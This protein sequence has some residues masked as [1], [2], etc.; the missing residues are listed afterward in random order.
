MILT[1]KPVVAAGT[2]L[3]LA[4]SVIERLAVLLAAGVTP[5]SG[6]RYVAEQGSG[7]SGEWLKA[8]VAAVEDGRDVADAILERV[9][10]TRSGDT[11]AWRGVAAAWS[12]ATVSGAPLAPTLHNFAASLR[13]LAQTQRDIV[14]A[15]T[16]PAATA[17]MVTG[18]PLVGILFGTLLGF[19]TLRTLF[20]TASGWACLAVGGALIVAA[21]AWNRRLIR[22]ALPAEVTPGLSLDLLAIAVSGGTSI[23]KAVSVVTEAC[24]R[25][26]V[27][28][29]G[30]V[31]AADIL[32]LSARA[33]IPAAVLLQSEAE[34][35][36]RLARNSSERA[37]ALLAVTLML[38]LGLCVLPAFML[39]GVAPLVV[40]VISSTVSAF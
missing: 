11:A 34:Q 9:E 30:R 29:D 6:W 38:P 2:E 15:L 33:G 23:A 31:A 28:D 35:I 20:G 14:V 16:A 19:D 21:R 7:L 12:V 3:E 32:S 37:V 13:S 10:Q 39:L 4:A 18:L 40:A 5:I 27:T 8:V 1:R 26:G 17:R 24:G 36:R 22:K 25:Y